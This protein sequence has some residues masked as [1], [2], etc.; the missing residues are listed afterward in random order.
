MEQQQEEYLQ[1]DFYIL[2]IESKKAFKVSKIKSNPDILTKI[3]KISIPI[4]LGATVGT[5]MSL[6][7]SILVPQ[8]L[9]QGVFIKPK[10][11][12]YMLN[13]QEKHQL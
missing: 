13:L 8:K 2:S 11:Q 3:L 5:I 9:L 4:S 10:Q 6:I 7:D 12:Y 1:E